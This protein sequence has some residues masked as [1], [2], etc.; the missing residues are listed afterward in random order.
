MNVFAGTALGALLLMTAGCSNNDP[1]QQA[2]APTFQMPVCSPVDP[3]CQLTEPP[4][5]DER[6]GPGAQ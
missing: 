4:R 1:E 6:P 2:A 3:Q 5:M